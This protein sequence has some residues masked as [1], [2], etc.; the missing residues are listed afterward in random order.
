MSSKVSSVRD[1]V[2]QYF[3]T[4]DNDKVKVKFTLLGLVTQKESN[5]I[6]LHIL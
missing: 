2:G 5:G 1:P 6:A 3:V 4:S